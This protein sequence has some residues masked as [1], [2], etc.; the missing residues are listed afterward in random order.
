MKQ[1]LTAKE[2]K[3]YFGIS[4]STLYTWRKNGRFELKESYQ[5]NRF[6]YLYK[7]DQALKELIQE[8]K[9][10]DNRWNK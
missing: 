1:W 7:R 10:I 6:G 4:S 2:A 5:G 3:E 9:N 8:L